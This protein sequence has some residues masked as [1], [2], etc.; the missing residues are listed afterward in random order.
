MSKRMNIY[1]MD[2]C[3]LRIQP[4][5]L[6]VQKVRDKGKAC[7]SHVATLAG[8]KPKPS[9]STPN[10]E[11]DLEPTLTPTRRKQFIISAA[12]ASLAVDVLMALLHK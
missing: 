11:P 12:R 3:N 9:R 4:N 1:V 10:L 6:L 7:V 5:N 8:H 2:G